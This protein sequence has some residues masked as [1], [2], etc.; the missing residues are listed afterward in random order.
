MHTIS[1]LDLLFSVVRSKN[2]QN[3]KTS[4]LFFFKLLKLERDFR[5]AVHSQN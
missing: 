3:F 2:A 1:F 4:K 5:V